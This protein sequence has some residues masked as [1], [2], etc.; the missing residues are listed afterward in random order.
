MKEA[1]SVN[2]PPVKDGACSVLIWAF[3]LLCKRHV[4]SAG[5]KI[6]MSC[7]R[8]R[9]RAIAQRERQYVLFFFQDRSRAGLYFSLLLFIAMIMQFLGDEFFL[10]QLHLNMNYSEVYSLPIRYRHWYLDR[11]AKH[12]ET[13]N[14]IMEDAQSSASSSSV[15]ENISNLDKFEAQMSNKFK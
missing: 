7:M 12:F 6:Q 5:D 15:S 13:K 10:L 9:A 3:C 8:A 14:K 4:R 1:C 11:L 2:V